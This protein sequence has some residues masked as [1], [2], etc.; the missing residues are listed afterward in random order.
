MG[1]LMRFYFN[2]QTKGVHNFDPHISP[3]KFYV[4]LSPPALESILFY[5]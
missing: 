3:S 4:F 2:K 1:A 5:T